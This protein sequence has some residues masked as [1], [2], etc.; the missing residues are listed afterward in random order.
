MAAIW[1][2]LLPEAEIGRHDS[3]F[4][5]GGTSL[6]LTR[7]HERLDSRYRGALKLVDLFRLN[8]VAAIAASLR[9]SGV[10][11]RDEISDLSFRL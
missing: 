6:T 2:D 11:Q 10:A 3:F 8:T 5:I 1:Q 7:L 9:E 4:A